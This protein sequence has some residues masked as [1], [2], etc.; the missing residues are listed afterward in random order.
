MWCKCVYVCVFIPLCCC[1]WRKC[2]YWQYVDFFLLV[3]KWSDPVCTTSICE[4]FN[5]V[6]WNI[7]NKDNDSS[8][9]RESG[10]HL[11]DDLSKFREIY[12]C[13]YHR[14][15]LSVIYHESVYSSPPPGRSRVGF[16]YWPFY[17]FISMSRLGCITF[18]FKFFYLLQVWKHFIAQD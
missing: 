18:T 12:F 4:R 13:I 6:G 11:I 7:P 15:N 16:T 9:S 5:S 17:I 2:C 10:S 8:S 1:W 3:Y 14:S